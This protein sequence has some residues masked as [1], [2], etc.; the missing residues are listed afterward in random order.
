MKRMVSSIAAVVLVDEVG[1][2]TVE[3]ANPFSLSRLVCSAVQEFEK[4][5]KHAFLQRC[6]DAVSAMLL[7]ALCECSDHTLLCHSP[8][9]L[10]AQCP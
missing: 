4:H 2:P 5:S 6:P 1:T 7:S 9:P 8:H 3:P 10:K